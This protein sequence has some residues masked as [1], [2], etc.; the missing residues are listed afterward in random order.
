MDHFQGFV[1]L[2]FK[3]IILS[4]SDLAGLSALH[5]LWLMTKVCV[6]IHANA[7]LSFELQ[8]QYHSKID[9]LI[10]E[11]VKEIISLLVSKVKLFAFYFVT[12]QKLVELWRCIQ[13]SHSFS[14]HR[15]IVGDNTIC[16]YY[17]C[18]QYWISKIKFY[19]NWVNNFC[20]V[21]YWDKFV[22]CVSA[23]DRNC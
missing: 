18:K 5:H 23:V 17:F 22:F 4:K 15:K 14:I 3:M 11:T 13:I 6:R 21:Y 1:L 2:M 8:Q 12:Q 7:F 10:E 20:A 19:N 9:D 16:K